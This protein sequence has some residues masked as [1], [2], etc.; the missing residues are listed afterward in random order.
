MDLK[1]KNTRSCTIATTNP[2]SIGHT[3][4][5]EAAVQAGTS[6]ALL[7]V[8]LPLRPFFEYSDDEKELLVSSREL[9][10]A[11]GPLPPSIIMYIATERLR[12]ARV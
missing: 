9:C 10:E 5:Y 6:L 2:I 12:I 1:E 8:G 3:R 4:K 11:V 7:D